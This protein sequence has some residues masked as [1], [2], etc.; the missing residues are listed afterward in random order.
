MSSLW[1]FRLHSL[2]SL[3][4]NRKQ[5]SS[6]KPVKVFLWLNSGLSSPPASNLLIPSFS[7]GL[8]RKLETP[9]PF[10]CPR[11]RSQS[12]YCEL[13]IK[14][15]PFKN[16]FIYQYYKL[17]YK[18]ILICFLKRHVTVM[19]A[20]N[21]VNKWGLDVGETKAACS[22]EWGSFFLFFSLCSMNF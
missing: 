8:S 19:F 13:Q 17:K 15:R 22:Q 12:S 9:P 16:T 20:G 1:L 3:N 11:R 6:V 14:K 21:T 7:W 10:D 18:H 5:R 4:F 2:P